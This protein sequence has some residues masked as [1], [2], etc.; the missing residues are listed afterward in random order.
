MQTERRLSVNWAALLS[1]AIFWSWGVN[2]YPMGS[3]LNDFPVNAFI[4]FLF[5]YFS[6]HYFTPN[7][8]TTFFIK[9]NTLAIFLFLAVVAV[10]LSWRHLEQSLWGDQ[11]YHAHFGSRHGQLVIFMIEQRMPILWSML[12]DV[13]VSTIVW[14]TNFIMLV[15]FGLL[16]I[17]LPK[18]FV[19]S[20]KFF[21]FLMLC[22]LLLTRLILSGEANIFSSLTGPFFML[23][24]YGADPHPVLRLF[25]LLLSSTIFGVSDFGYR[26]AA[27]TGYLLFLLF[28]YIN[29]KD[30]V[31][32]YLALAATLSI[33][34]LPILWHVAYLAEQSVWSTLA[35]ASVFVLLFSS[36]DSASIPFIP[37]I[38]LVILA[39]LMRS[40]AFVAFAPIAVV[41]VYCI[42]KGNIKQIDRAPILILSTALIIIVLISVLRGSPATESEGYLSKFLYALTNNIPGIAAASVFGLIPFFFVGFAF[43]ATSLESMIL[44]FAALSFFAFCCLVYYAPVARILW[45]VGR[46]QSEM[47]VPLITAGIVAYC[48]TYAQ[49]SF[50]QWF[51]IMPLI[52]LIALN[53]FSLITFDA[54]SFRLFTDNP[55]PGEAVKSEIEYPSRDAF[56]FLGEHKL[57]NHTFYVGIYYGGFVSALRG[58]SA[59]QY[60]NFSLLNNRH[61][62]G[63]SVKAEAIS[64]D[65]EIR[66]VVI[67]P[68]ADSETIKGLLELGWKGQ[69]D[70]THAQSGRKLTVITREKI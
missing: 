49:N 68:E 43:R 37:A 3:I 67:E 7:F 48:L 10:T 5:C 46:Y 18:F 69:Y 47:Y 38:S 1:F 64:G 16:F 34:T 31:N 45:G 55:V 61:R 23:N 44:F 21:V 40:P 26:A 8:R 12:K 14:F 29:L 24:E 63:F 15:F 28:I 25:P 20:K 62:N 41:L 4:I 39:T 33:G 58:Y 70:F 65:S 66:S 11:I 17:L 19:F 9:K 30:R 56:Q 22:A 50:R 27:F 52:F 51:S 6:F 13:R 2:S 59:E 60:V 32:L 36:R 54:R 42:F 35:S 53:I 57:Q